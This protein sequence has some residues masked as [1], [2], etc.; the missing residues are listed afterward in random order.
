MNENLDFNIHHGREEDP[1]GDGFLLQA[2]VLL[3]KRSIHFNANGKT[4]AAKQVAS[5]LGNPPSVRGCLGN[6][7]RKGTLIILR[8]FDSP[9]SNSP[10]M[11]G[12]STNSLQKTHGD[13][14]HDIRK[15]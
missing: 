12:K 13:F 11:L 15:N 4:S 1:S 7:P 10:K 9:C 3:R 6:V 8:T 5:R 14:L 2:D